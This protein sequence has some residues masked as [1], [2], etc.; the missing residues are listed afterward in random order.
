MTKLAAQMNELSFIC[1]LFLVTSFVYFQFTCCLVTP[2]LHMSCSGN[3]HTMRHLQ[4]F[5]REKSVA[6][7]CIQPHFG[8]VNFLSSFAA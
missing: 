6:V 3:D 8:R 7:I 5:R 4:C 2:H 1:Y